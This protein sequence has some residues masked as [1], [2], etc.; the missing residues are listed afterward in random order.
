MCP[1]KK[2]FNTRIAREAKDEQNH[3]CGRD[4]NSDNIS[5]AFHT[6]WHKRI[7]EFT[8]RV[9]YNWNIVDSC[10]QIPDNE[11]V[12]SIFF[13]EIRTPIFINLSL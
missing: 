4:T 1:W 6:C 9:R 11:D 10:F 13:A 2:S 8:N 3:V 12:I 7:R 5:F